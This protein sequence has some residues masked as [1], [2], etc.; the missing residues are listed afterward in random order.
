MVSTEYSQLGKFLKEQRVKSSFTQ[1]EVSQALKVHVQFVSN[2]ERGTCAPP[3]HCF[4]KL[5]DLL[6]INRQKIVEVMVIDAK[7]AIEEKVFASKKKKAK[8]G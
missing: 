2:W 8:A 1:N 6:H 7:A 5:I 3:A 4:D